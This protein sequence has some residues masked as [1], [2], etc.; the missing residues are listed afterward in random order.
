MTW[1]PAF[2]KQYQTLFGSDDESDDD[3]DNNESESDHPTGPYIS[4]G[5][6]TN[7]PSTQPT[8]S[9]N[10]KANPPIT[11]NAIKSRTSNVIQSNP[12]RIPPK[13]A[14]KNVNGKATQKARLPR[15]LNLNLNED[16]FAKASFRRRDPPTGEF[17]LPKM[18]YDV[19]PNKAKMFN[20]LEELGVRMESF[21]RPPQDREDRMLLIWGRGENIERTIRE[22]REWCSTSKPVRGRATQPRDWAPKIYSEIGD[23]RKRQKDAIKKRAEL[24]KFQQVPAEGQIFDHTDTFPWAVEE[25]RPQEILGDGLEALDSIR[26]AY[27][28]HIIFDNQHSVFR[29]LTKYEDSVKQTQSR[30]EGVVKEYTARLNRPIAK[31]YIEPAAFANH[32][33]DV[34]IATSAVSSAPKIPIL[35]GKPLEL[36]ARWKWLKTSADLVAQSNRGIENALRMTIPNLVFYRGQVRMRVH[37][38]TFALT[39]F[40]WPATAS[41]I[42]FEEFVKSVTTQGTKGTM[43]RE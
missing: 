3:E 13:G 10:P 22:L 39:M 11:N 16:N 20:Y 28:C 17:V 26:M 32:R 1:D 43:I 7:D 19:E 29:I 31:Y 34:R 2:R 38:G 5:I 21:I 30:L 18:C 9:Q 41:A 37:F 6:Q 40:R 14:H 15:R 27:K 42:A 36:E 24:Q 4:G 35:T 33:E 25:V 23:I 12:G 8:V